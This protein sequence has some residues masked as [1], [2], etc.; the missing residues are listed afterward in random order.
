VLCVLAECMCAVFLSYIESITFKKH[1]KNN[2]LRWFFFFFDL[3]IHSPVARKICKRRPTNFKSITKSKTSSS[4]CLSLQLRSRFVCFCVINSG[5][6]ILTAMT[7]RSPTRKTKQNKT[8]QNKTKQIKI[9]IR[10][11]QDCCFYID[12]LVA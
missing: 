5:C 7:R 3:F 6:L 9:K 1:K 12:F 4:L 11:I 2:N 10:E 8:K